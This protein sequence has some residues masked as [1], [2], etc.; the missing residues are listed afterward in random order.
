MHEIMFS[1]HWVILLKAIVMRKCAE[2]KDEESCGRRRDK[3]R[4]VN[5]IRNGQYLPLAI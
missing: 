1:R 4:A 5:G 3:A 2:G